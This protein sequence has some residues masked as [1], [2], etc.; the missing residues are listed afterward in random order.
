MAEV[1]RGLTIR[2]FGDPAPLLKEIEKVKK[3]MA[4][5]GDGDS[6]K[7]S[8]EN[9][10]KSLQ[11]QL[12]ATEVNA[13]N[14]QKSLRGIGR[15]IKDS[16]GSEALAASQSAAKALAGIGAALAAAGA[17]A[18]QEAGRFQQIEAAFTNL[19]GSS[20]KAGDYI[21]ELQ[22]F[23]K[24]TPFTFEDLVVGAQRFMAMGFTAEEVIPT[25]KAV[26]DA[27]A[28]VGL[29]AEGINRI[30]LALGQ[31]KAKGTV[32]AE[33]FRQL[34]EA[35]IPAWDMLAKKMGVDVATAMKQVEQRAVSAQTGIEALVE[36]MNGKYG[37]MM[38]QQAKTITGSWA[39]MT[40]GV[41]QSLAQ[42]GLKIDETFD[43]SGTL[44]GIGTALS[45]FARTVQDSGF[46]EALKELVP[47][48]LAGSIAAF[49]VMLTAVAIPAVINATMAF[50]GM[51]VAA[52]ASLGPFAPLALALA[53]VAGA[54]VTGYFEAQDYA[55]GIDSIGDSARYTADELDDLKAAMDRVRGEVSQDW[56]SSG[57][58]DDWDKVSPNFN[59]YEVFEEPKTNVPKD[60][61]DKKKTTKLSEEERAV[62]ALIKKYADASEQ[63]R[64]R[65]KV[66]MEV[67]EL[68][69]SMLI[70]EAKER[71]EL[72][73]KIAGFTANHEAVIEGYQ[74]EL[75]LAQQIEE[76]GTRQRT[77]DGINAQ[78]A[79]QEELYKKQVEAA[80]WAANYK[81]L[82][83][84]SK[85]L[86]DQ[87]FGDPE[88]MKARAEQNKQTL[89][90]FMSKVDAIEAK[91]KGSFGSDDLNEDTLGKESQGFLSDIL[92]KS[93]E[94]LQEE[95]DT[96]GQQLET[97]ADFIKTKMAE[98]TAAENENLSVG[99]EWA[100]KQESWISS[101]G[102][103]M[104]DALADWI[105]GAKGIGEA[106]RDMVSDL[107]SQT[108]TLLAKWLSVYAIMSIV[109]NPRT[110]AAAA[111][112][113]VLGV[114]DWS[115]GQKAGGGLVSGAGTGTSDSIPTLLSNGE[116]V[117]RA[118]AVDKLGVPLLN[119]LNSGTLPGAFASGGFVGGPS[120][121][122]RTPDYS[123]APDFS[124]DARKAGGR[125]TNYGA[126]EKTAVTLNVSAI[127]ASSFR[128]FL[129]RGGLDVI[130]QA[131]YDNNR[132]FATNTGVW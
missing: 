53:A 77:I 111:N 82:Q 86:M 124:R 95:Y 105:T 70:G 50:A 84:E 18:V 80:N 11:K 85:T 20:E 108:A 69:A 59:L 39:I 91:E 122:G 131:L 42:I 9:K 14:L 104:G 7:S 31:I 100:K 36:G 40:D 97:F 45:D 41:Q 58:S 93:P 118:A 110:A 83:K 44:R 102:G 28:G 99:E 128:S 78:I 67:A 75:A 101:I 129:S 88:D 98:A 114:G 24:K 120:I 37:G 15:S 125:D 81:N 19:L 87:V 26:G 73:N 48:E 126:E 21:R 119:V 113:M 127:D 4:S 66:A 103:S 121:V 47:P 74:K 64:L 79:A 55:K 27:A 12:A 90:D 22:D 72:N 5:L 115:W 35:G 76:A 10:L 96:K 65:G 46:T 54:F 106:M 117:I 123:S 30:S 63:A 2:L 57:E 61:P 32:Q 71:E 49:G 43:I 25:L 17:K 107:L 13:K 6:K 1:L 68:S 51:A 94:E 109:G 132:D 130:R 52:W 34:A 116:Y 112:K 23:T 92:K 56:M 60:T 16:I 62:E 33:E 89:E 29:G 3:E 38:E 8:Y